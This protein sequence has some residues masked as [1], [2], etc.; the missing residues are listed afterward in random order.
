MSLILHY[1]CYAQIISCHFSS[2]TIRS[3][4]E[5]EIISIAHHVSKVGLHFYTFLYN[6]NDLVTRNNAVTFCFYLGGQIFLHQLSEKQSYWILFHI[7][8]LLY[9]ILFHLVGDPITRLSATFSVF[10]TDK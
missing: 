5:M 2:L 6:Y 4:K 9:S 3:K 1:N 7:A 8:V 10:F